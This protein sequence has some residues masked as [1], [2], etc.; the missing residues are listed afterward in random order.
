MFNLNVDIMRKFK[1]PIGIAALLLI[2]FACAEDLVSPEESLNPDVDVDT[3]YLHDKNYIER[4]SGD[5]SSN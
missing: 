5:G 3:C 4:K 2:M 1:K